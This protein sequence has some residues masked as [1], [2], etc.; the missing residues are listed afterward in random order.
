MPRIDRQALHDRLARL[1]GGRPPL[2]P[3]PE[4]EPDDGSGERGEAVVVRLLGAVMLA[5]LLLTDDGWRD[6]R[7]GEVHPA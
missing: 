4:R 1:S 5:D 3:E 2:P 7:T 6:R